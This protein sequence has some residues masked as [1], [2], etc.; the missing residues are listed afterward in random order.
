MPAFQFYPGDWLKDPALRSVSTEARGLWIDMLCLMH[1]ADR[2]G[3]LELNGQP[4]T[5]DQLARMT[6]CSAARV[7]HLLQEL[8]T[9]GVCSCTEHGV[10][11]NRRMVKDERRRMQT[12]VRVQTYRHKTALQTPDVT[13]KKRSGNTA[14]SSSTSV[15]KGPSKKPEDPEEWARWLYGR[16]PKKKN[17]PLVEQMVVQLW[18]NTQHPQELFARID[19]AH[20]VMCATV[21]WRKNH[22]NF[23][24]SLDMWLADEGYEGVMSGSGEVNPP[25]ANYPSLP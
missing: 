24:P 19:A 4:V 20:E 11:Y 21:D 2:K 25:E 16:H 10:I 18:T 9:S 12:K 6:G 3:Y 17:K 7:P 13:L 1:E 5:P 15:I 8:I 22:G 23:A 14:S